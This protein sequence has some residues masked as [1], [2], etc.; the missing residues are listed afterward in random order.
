MLSVGPGHSKLPQT[1][2]EVANSLGDLCVISTS[3]DSPKI[4]QPEPEILNSIGDCDFCVI[5]IA[6][7]SWWLISH[8]TLHYLC[9]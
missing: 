4:P 1:V 8:M 6:R 9:D 3:R 7:G 5:Y 2:P